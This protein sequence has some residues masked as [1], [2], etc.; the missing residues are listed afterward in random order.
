MKQELREA[1]EAGERAL[2]SLRQAHKELK[3]AKNWGI[4]DLFGGG[5]IV[6]LFKRSRMKGAVRWMEEAQKDLRIFE[7]ELRD[8]DVASGL[9]M[10]TDD[11]LTFADF[12]FDGVIADYLMQARISEAKENVEEAID[13]VTYLLATLQERYAQMEK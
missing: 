2:F 5:M 12:F 6:D 11:F 10:E 13:R 9:S 3:N 4:A 1:I 8:V 7:T